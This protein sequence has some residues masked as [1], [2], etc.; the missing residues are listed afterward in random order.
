MDQY[1]CRVLQ[2]VSVKD[3]GADL[4]EVR[5]SGPPQKCFSRDSSF[6][7]EV[8]TLAGC[9]IQGF[10]S[11]SSDSQKGVRTCSLLHT[12]QHTC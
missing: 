2:G 8:V 11:C 5:G 12:C 6:H 9:G 10:E 7:P 3:G 4:L 1:S